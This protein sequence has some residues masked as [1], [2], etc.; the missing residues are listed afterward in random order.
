MEFLVEGRS[1]SAKWARILMPHMIERLKLG[2]SRR[3]VQVIFDN[4]DNTPYGDSNR[5]EAHGVCLDFTEMNDTYL[6]V[7]R[8]NRNL[9]QIGLNLAHEMIHVKQMATGLLRN[10]ENNISHW[11]RQQYGGETSYLDSPWEIQAFSGQ[12]LLYRRV[13][14]ALI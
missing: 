3:L 2:R 7:L 12:E 9:N 1:N 14:E 6:V 11:R 8:P 13:V 4:I 5:T 10:G